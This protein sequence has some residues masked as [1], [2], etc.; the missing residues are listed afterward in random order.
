M[1]RKSY[2]W[3]RHTDVGNVPLSYLTDAE[4]QGVQ[5]ALDISN[6]D[7]ERTRLTLLNGQAPWRPL[8][9]SDLAV[10]EDL[11]PSTIGSLIRQARTALFGNLTDSAI[12]KRSQ[13]GGGHRA[14]DRPC[15]EPGCTTLIAAHLP[16]Q[17]RYCQTHRTPA[18]RTQRSR[19]RTRE[20]S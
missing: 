2:A 14:N 12:Y 17:R 13:R 20:G 15:A 11:S 19:A 10:R 6:D 9:L 7:R 1:A 3:A 4:R 8:T 18:A 16:R 5:Y